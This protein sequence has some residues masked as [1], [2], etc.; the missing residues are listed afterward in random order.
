MD[1]GGNQGGYGQGKGQGNGQGNGQGHDQDDVQGNDGSDEQDNQSLS[2]D[3]D[4][5]AHIKEVDDDDDDFEGTP[6]DEDVQKARE[7]AEQHEL[8]CKK[9]KSDKLADT[10][11]LDENDISLLSDAITEVSKS[12][13]KGISKKKLQLTKKLEDHINDLTEAINKI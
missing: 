4:D 2:S 8:Q 12:R 3:D 6:T 7:E 11:N 5:S 13:L 9:Q 10:G 1:H